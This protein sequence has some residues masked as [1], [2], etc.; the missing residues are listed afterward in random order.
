MLYEAED[1]YV[2]L[3]ALCKGIGLTR[4]GYMGY[5]ILTDQVLSP[6]GY[7]KT[8]TWVEYNW[9]EVEHRR[10]EKRGELHYRQPGDTLWPDEWPLAELARRRAVGSLVW[11]AQYQGAPTTPE[12]NLFKRWAW[13]HID[14]G[15][16]PETEMTVRFW[17]LGY[18][19]APRTPTTLSAQRCTVPAGASALPTSSVFGRRPASATGG[20][21][22][23]LNATRDYRVTE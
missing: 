14:A 16:V 9:I 4:G 2:P 10:Y 23:R 15:A 11:S 5:R 1:G 18:S 22:P 8:P 6:F 13:R 12:G 19:D 20:S 17:D 21:R 3:S 7:N